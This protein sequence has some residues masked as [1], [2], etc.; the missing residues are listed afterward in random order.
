M[1]SRDD[2]AERRPRRRHGRE[3]RHAS[4]P[5]NRP[6]YLLRGLGG[7]VRVIPGLAVRVARRALASSGWLR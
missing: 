1:A 3:R 4:S 2:R 5:P 6:G 7:T